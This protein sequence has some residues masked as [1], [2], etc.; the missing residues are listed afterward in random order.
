METVAIEIPEPTEML[1]SITPRH[2]LDLNDW[3]LADVET[4][5]E[6]S[7]VMAQV[8]GRTIKKVPALQG[9]TIG[10]LFFENSTRTRISFERAARAQSADVVSFASGNSSMS[11]GESLK[12]TLRTIDAMQ[13]DLY[14]VRHQVAGVPHQLTQ[15]TQASIVNAGDGRRAHPT[16]ALLDAYTFKTRYKDFQ[17]FPGMKL[18]IVGDIAHSRVARSNIA[19]WTKLGARIAL[20]GPA[21]LV[22]PEFAQ[23]PGVTRHHRLEEALEEASAVMAL[24]LQHERMTSGL[25]PSIT[26]YASRYQITEDALRLAHP[27]ALVFHPGPINRDVEISGGLADSERSVIEAQVANGV[28]IRMAVLYT[29]LVGKK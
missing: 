26:E 14:V 8:M 5:F 11:K 25:M 12:D 6:T 10:T 23:L 18:A 4:L 27:N 2:L 20:C 21:T 22:P 7:D 13:A 3:S 28:P 15:W 19:L 1:N 9:F 29:L 17:G 24:R 16:Q